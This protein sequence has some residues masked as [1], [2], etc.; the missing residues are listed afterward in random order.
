MDTNQIYIPDEMRQRYLERRF[1]DIQNCES[2]LKNLDWLYFEQLGHQLKGNAA[3]YGYHHLGDIASKL[4]TSALD[5]DLV[6]LEIYIHA[7]RIWVQTY[8]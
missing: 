4:E 3:S 6:K 8:Q 1:Q 5:K 2:K 7:F